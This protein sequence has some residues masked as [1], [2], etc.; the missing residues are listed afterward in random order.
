M[1][2][3]S[4]LLRISTHS[5]RQAPPN[6][7]EAALVEEQIQEVLS[8]PQLHDEEMAVLEA[9]Q[10]LSAATEQLTAVTTASETATR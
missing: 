2:L 6:E 3:A 7:A 9:R 5:T 4:F 1:S 10:K 8:D